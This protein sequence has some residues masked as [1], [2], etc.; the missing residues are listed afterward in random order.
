MVNEGNQLCRNL[1]EN[2]ERVNKFAAHYFKAAKEAE[3]SIK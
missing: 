2:N 3:D 1:K